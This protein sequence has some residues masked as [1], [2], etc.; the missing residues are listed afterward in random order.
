MDDFVLSDGVQ[1]EAVRG[2]L[3]LLDETLDFFSVG[4]RRSLDLSVA[5]I[6]FPFRPR[7]FTRNPFRHTISQRDF[8]I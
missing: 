6:V 3:L 8:T 1:E 2:L 7:L 5:I 4:I